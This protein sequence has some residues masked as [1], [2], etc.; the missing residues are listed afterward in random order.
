MLDIR[1]WK[2]SFTISQPGISIIQMIMVELVERR[3][4]SSWTSLKEV[5]YLPH[6]NE[7]ALKAGQWF[8][9]VHGTVISEVC[10]QVVIGNSIFRGLGKCDSGRL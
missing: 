6:Y 4:P 3:F 7:V 5:W 1:L 8:K 10:I 9:G 2:L